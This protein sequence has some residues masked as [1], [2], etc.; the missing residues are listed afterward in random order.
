MQTTDRSLQNHENE[1]N[2]S[3]GQ[4]EVR[5]RKKIIRGLNLSAVTLSTVKVTKLRILL[6]INKI[7]MICLAE[8]G[9]NRELIYSGEGKLL[10]K[11][12]R[13]RYVHLTKEKR[14]HKRQTHP[15]A[16]EL[17]SN[18]VLNGSFDKIKS[19]VVKLKGLCAKMN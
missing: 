3:I 4:G 5:L 12:L 9:L 14:I 11:K 16:R 19:L 8:H 1:H 6:K 7:G 10:D 13:V 15:L 17:H 18:Y 2:R